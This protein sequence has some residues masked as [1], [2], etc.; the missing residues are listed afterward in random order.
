MGRRDS[1]TLPKLCS[2]LHDSGLLENLTMNYAS[3]GCGLAAGGP[4]R[5]W[6]VLVVVRWFQS[7]KGPIYRVS[8]LVKIL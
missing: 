6:Y 3:R 8:Q 1:L 7:V 2:D 5:D 4:A